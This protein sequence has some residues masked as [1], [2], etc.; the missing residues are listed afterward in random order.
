MAIIYVA[1]ANEVTDGTAAQILGM[2]QTEIPVVLVT[3]PDNFK[4][5]EELNKLDKY[6]LCDYEEM[7]WSYDWSR[8]THIFGN[9]TYKF[10]DL[11]SGDEWRKFEDFVSLKEP[12]LYFKRE[13]LEK[14]RSDYL[15][16][17]DYS[18]WYKTDPIQSKEDFD[19]RAISLF[20]FWGRSNERRLQIHSDIWEWAIRKG[21]SVCDNIYMYD[22]FVECEQ[23]MKIV[24]IWM[25]HYHRIQMEY[26]L[27]KNGRS[28]LSLAPPGAGLKTFRLVESSINSTLVKQKDNLAYS[29]DWNE[30]NCILYEESKELETIF[31][32]L[33]N[34]NLYEIY[35]E[36]VANCQRYEVNGYLNNY[37]GPIINK[38]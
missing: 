24:S 30:T 20:Y 16:P 13:L 9:N 28:K 17:I 19:K 3:R 18:A 22:K 15:H 34:P 7:G 1:N 33:E 35:K 37:V 21:Y 23:G 29:Y 31:A 32:A 8:G 5:N 10:P 2:L 4:F 25:P 26:L 27:Y 11:Y 12:L 14:D 38:L 6:I 36:S